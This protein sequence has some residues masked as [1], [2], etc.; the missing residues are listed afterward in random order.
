M[1]TFIAI[2]TYSN[3]HVQLTPSKYVKKFQPLLGTSR[4]WIKK[5]WHKLIFVAPVGKSV[6]IA[7]AWCSTLE[8]S[9]SAAESIVNYLTAEVALVTIIL[10]TLTSIALELGQE[11]KKK[12]LA[13]YTLSVLS[14][15]LAVVSLIYGV[16]VFSTVSSILFNG[17]LSVSFYAAVLKLLTTLS[18]G[19]ILTNS[20]KFIK[21]SYQHLLEYAVRLTL[22][23]LFRMLLI[24]SANFRSAFRSVVGFS[25][26]LYVLIFFGST[27]SG[28]REAG[29]KYYFLSTFSSGLRIYGIFRLFITVDTLNFFE[30]DQ[31]LK[32]NSE[33]VRSAL[34]TLQIAIGLLL[35]GIFFKLSAF[36]GHLWAA[37][38]YEGSPDPITGFFRLPVKLAVFSFLFSTLAVA[39][40]SLV[41]IWQPFVRIAA[42]G[43]LLWG[44]VGAC[45]EKNTKRFLAYASINQMGFLLRGVAAASFHGYRATRVYLLIYTIRNFGFLTVFLNARTKGRDGLLYLTDFR[46]VGQANWLISWTVARVLLSRAGIPPLAGFFGKYFLLLHVQE[47]KLYPLVFVALLTSLISAYYYLRIIKTL[48]FEGKASRTKVTCRLSSGQQTT[49]FISEGLLWIFIIFSGSV[50]TLAEKRT[51]SLIAPDV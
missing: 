47:A 26:N 6:E 34:Y 51:Q 20:K 25:L 36:P 28:A 14:E 23:V 21:E 3:K 5:L 43:S 9:R 27:R 17:Y 41:F 50:V 30:R 45:A 24:S 35:T 22:T 31:L 48:W 18:C 2:N 46:G 33:L 19:F 1:H 44:C 4:R 29:I 40:H 15:G 12:D 11:R 16:F 37:D 39:L 49:F 10:Y 8:K 38:V 32:N 13:L 7:E 42:A